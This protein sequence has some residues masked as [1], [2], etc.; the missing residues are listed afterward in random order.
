MDDGSSGVAALLTEPV[1]V[2]ERLGRPLP[3][4]WVGDPSRYW[5]DRGA[6]SALEVAAQAVVP[7][8]V[9]PGRGERGRARV[10]PETSRRPGGSVPD[11]VREVFA[12]LPE[13]AALT[14]REIAQRASAGYVAGEISQGAISAALNSGRLEGFE[15]V[16]AVHPGG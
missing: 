12:S 3:V 9:D 14:V 13:T 8:D 15:W 2:A 10:A 7:V 11:H 16:P 4:R 5:I 1:R 6:A